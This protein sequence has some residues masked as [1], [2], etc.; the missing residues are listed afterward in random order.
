V[1]PNDLA[2]IVNVAKD[3]I[4]PVTVQPNGGFSATVTADL[5]DVL[6]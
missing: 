3:W 4:L 6:H 2:F 1:G 5:S